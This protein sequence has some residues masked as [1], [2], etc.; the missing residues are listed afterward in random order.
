V[1]EYKFVADSD[2][3]SRP[4]KDEHDYESFV[5]VIALNSLPEL[6]IL[7]FFNHNE[8]LDYLVLQQSATLHQIK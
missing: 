2:S 4:Y 3:A 1:V 8:N 5:F 6:Q 7:T